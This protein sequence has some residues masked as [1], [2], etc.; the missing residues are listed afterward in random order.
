MG[1]FFSSDFTILLTIFFLLHAV[2]TNT[3]VDINAQLDVGVADALYARA[4]MENTI[5][6]LETAT[7]CKPPAPR[8]AAPGSLHF[9]FVLFF[10]VLTTKTFTSL[11][12]SI[13]KC[14]GGVFYCAQQHA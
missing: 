6:K 3:I 11:S 1:S 2:M 9:S 7:A 4:R 10:I 13:S 14:T 8:C 5:E 12:S